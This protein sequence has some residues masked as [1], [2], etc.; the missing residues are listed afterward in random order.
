MPDRHENSSQYRFGFQGQ[1]KDDE[2]KGQGNSYDFGARMF[3][4]RIA[5]FIAVDPKWREFQFQSPFAYALNNPI[6]FIDEYGEGPKDRIKAARKYKGTAYKKQ[7]NIKLRTGM[8]SKALEYMD[9][10]ELVCRVLA[11]D[12]FTNGVESMPT[13]DIMTWMED[14]WKETPTPKAGDIIVWN[15]HTAI[16]TKD[17]DE[18]EGK[19]HV[20]HATQYADVDGVVEEEYSLSYYKK[21]DAKFYTPKIDN[22]DEVDIVAPIDPL[23]QKQK[24]SETTEKVGF[25]QEVVNKIVD[26]FNTLASVKDRNVKKYEKADD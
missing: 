10:S 17:Y 5:R 12:Q 25:L 22:P 21:K 20:I 13:W 18:K 11:Y 14:N 24:K 26:S 6:R 3:D 1:E 7:T 4:P 23:N 2:L 8:D 9:C 19:L 16:V 15:G